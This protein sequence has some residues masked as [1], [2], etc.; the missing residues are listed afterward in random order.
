MFAAP[1]DGRVLA[2]PVLA[3][4]VPSWC[5]R[6]SGCGLGVWLWGL[7]GGVFGDCGEQFGFWYA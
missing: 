2:A 1:G 3:G 7:G 4:A 5:A 6:G